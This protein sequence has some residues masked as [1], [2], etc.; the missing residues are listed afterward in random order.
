MT[1]HAPKSIPHFR[2]S[3]TLVELLT[4]IAIIGIMAGM[5]LY[6]LAGAQQDA[7]VARTRSTIQKINEIVLQRWEEFRYRAPKIKLPSDWLQPQS[8]P[9]MN[10]QPRVSPIEGARLRMI[11]LRDVMR[12][13]MPDRMSDVLYPPTLYKIAGLT[14]N[15]DPSDDVPYLLPSREVP[16]AFNNFRQKV[17]LPVIANPYSGPVTRIP[18]PP[19]AVPSVNS[20]EWLYQI[21]AASNFEG[22][23]GLEHFRPSEIG[24]VDDDGF[25]EFLDA[26]GR[27]IWWLRWP[28]GYPSPLNDAPVSALGSV[29]SSYTDAMDP[30]RTDWRWRMQGTMKRP[31]TLVPLIVSS[32]SDGVFNIKFDDVG[33]PV[34]VALHTWTGTTPPLSIGHTNGGLYYYPDPYGLYSGAQLGSLENTTSGEEVD[35]ISNYDLLLE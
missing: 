6:T 16:G 24:D 33:T 14:A 30:L 15:G 26:W 18:P 32:G 7:Y 3:F 29:D 13:E 22:G 20:A 27:S 8:L 11:V 10:G 21:V 34:I 28:A 19:A 17:F 31:W 1:H 35:N 4:V 5:V 23:S 25:P 12:M 9:N 2:A